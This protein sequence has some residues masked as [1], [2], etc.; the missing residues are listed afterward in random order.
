[1]FWD[2]KGNFLSS[3]EIADSA[4]I[5]IKIGIH[6]NEVVSTVLVEG[7]KVRGFTLFNGKNGKQ[8]PVNDS[9]PFEGEYAGLYIEKNEPKNVWI[10]FTEKSDIVW[11]STSK[12]EPKKQKITNSVCDSNLIVDQSRGIPLVY[13]TNEKNETILSRITSGIIGEVNE[14][15]LELLGGESDLMLCAKGQG[16]I[17]HTKKKPLSGS[18]RVFCKLETNGNQLLLIQNHD[19][20]LFLQEADSLIWKR[21]ESFADASSVVSLPSALFSKTH[22]FDYFAITN[23][24]TA[25]ISAV[26][27]FP[28]SVLWKKHFVECLNSKVWTLV[29][30]NALLF[31]QGSTSSVLFELN[32][33][34]GDVLSKRKFDLT[35]IFHISILEQGPGSA[36]SPQMTRKKNLHSTTFLAAFFSSEKSFFWRGRGTLKSGQF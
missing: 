2:K 10:G 17:V 32:L 25:T 26:R 8:I 31:C 18:K 12:H 34:S 20:D 11:R 28:F 30:Q 21:D 5:E 23:E 27:V 29:T 22:G 3:Q 24:K 9:I 6:T 35:N 15:R 1:M 33:V 36:L 7:K 19:G 4:G 13:C 14:L 16:E